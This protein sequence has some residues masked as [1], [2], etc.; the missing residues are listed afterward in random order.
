M[1]SFNPVERSIARILAK[2]PFIKK[3]VKSAYAHFVFIRNKKPF[4]H[5]SKFDLAVISSESESFFGYYDKSPSNKNGLV[6]CHNTESSATSGLPNVNSS[7]NIVLFEKNVFAKK[8][9]IPACAYNWQQGTRLHWLNDELFIYNDFNSTD[10][11]YVA[12]VISTRNLEQEREFELPVQDSF[13]TDYFLS[14]NYRRLMTLRPDYGYRNL[15]KMSNEEMNSLDND[16]IWRVDY[17]TGDSTLLVSL[18]EMCEVQSSPIFS[19]AVH[20]ANHVMISPNGK[21]FIF[22]HRYLIGKRRFDRLFLADAE[23]GELTLLSDFGMVSHCFWADD[24]TVLG[25]MR[26]P[27]EVDG[28]WLL[29]VNNI[30]FKAFE[31]EKLAKYGDGHPHVNGDWFITD[32]YPDKA[33]MQHLILCNWKTGEV[34]EIGEFFHGFQFQGESRCDLHPRFSQDGKTVFFDSV[35]SGERRLY[36]MDVF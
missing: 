3:I 14:I 18:A 10:N 28:Y 22:M 17:K 4:A 31:H 36:S 34:K 33:R 29:D 25:Y 9:S 27:E 2:A 24:N 6:L 13:G 1:S 5:E 32:T 16:G 21:R 30:E 12:K 19:E 7:V 26:G 23:T 11:R 15:P 35:F 20:K 8:M